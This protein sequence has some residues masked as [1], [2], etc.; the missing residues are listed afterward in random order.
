MALPALLLIGAALAAAAYTPSMKSAVSDKPTPKPKT[1][2]KPKPVEGLEFVEVGGGGGPVSDID[3]RLE[4]FYAKY[5]LRRL[6][7]G[8]KGI[9]ES[10]RGDR[11]RR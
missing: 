10:L 11:D 7:K 2:L 3:K 4:A 9:V 5:P 6:R 1:R 8:E